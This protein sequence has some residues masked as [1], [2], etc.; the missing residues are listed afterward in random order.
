MGVKESRIQNG[1][2]Q[3]VKDVKVKIRGWNELLGSFCFQFSYADKARLEDV[4][5]S[6]IANGLYV[7]GKV[8]P[9]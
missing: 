5:K 6:C 4:G 8:F 9:K 7:Q 2:G 3:L 1:A